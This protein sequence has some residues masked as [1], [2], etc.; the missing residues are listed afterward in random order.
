M[1]TREYRGGWRRS[2]AADRLSLGMN[3]AIEHARQ[4]FYNRLPTLEDTTP[5]T[6]EYE[7]LFRAGGDDQP[8]ARPIR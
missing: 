1:K 8:T 2:P 5:W 4:Y 7:R 3:G 6:Y